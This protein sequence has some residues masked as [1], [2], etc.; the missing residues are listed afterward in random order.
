MRM[1][2]GVMRMGVAIAEG[3]PVRLFVPMA[4]LMPAM[5]RSKILHRV[6]RG[7]KGSVEERQSGHHQRQHGHQHAP[8]NTLN[9]PGLQL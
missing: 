9:A 2:A 5:V 4:G 7:T 1:I 3:V 8:R 6:M